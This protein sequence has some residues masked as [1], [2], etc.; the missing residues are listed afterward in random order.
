MQEVHTY[1]RMG[2]L[3]KQ[4]TQEGEAQTQLTYRPPLCETAGIMQGTLLYRSP[5]RW[6]I[7]SQET[8]GKPLEMGMY[9]QTQD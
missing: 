2:I 6:E 9:H 7:Q 3:C 1:Q 4:L 8:W 5:W